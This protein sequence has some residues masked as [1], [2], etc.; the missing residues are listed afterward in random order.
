M[1]TPRNKDPYFRGLNAYFGTA[2]N[3]FVTVL[4]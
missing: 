3:L 4:I 1:Y 2:S